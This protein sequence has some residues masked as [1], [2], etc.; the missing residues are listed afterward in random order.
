MQNSK[1]VHNAV[2]QEQL[3]ITEPSPEMSNAYLVKTKQCLKAADL[4][5]KAGIYENATSES[6]FGIYNTVLSLFYK[7][8]IKCENHTVA[9]ILIKDLFKLD[10]IYITFQTLK[11]ER[12]D[13]QYYIPTLQTKQVSQEQCRNSLASS[14]KCVS[15][16]KSI[17]INFRQEDIKKIREKSKQYF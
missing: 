3:K 14:H 13:N 17:I 8:G 6:Y 9:V 5:Y 7:C 11:K 2:Q 4:L 16:I 10:E 15:K 12:I 1:V